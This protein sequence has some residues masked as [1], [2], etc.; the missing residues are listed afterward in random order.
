MATYEKYTLQLNNEKDAAVIAY[1]RRQ[2]NKNDCI[3]QA[4]IERMKKESTDE[5]VSLAR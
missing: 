5:E 2:E 3:R 1:L 4:L